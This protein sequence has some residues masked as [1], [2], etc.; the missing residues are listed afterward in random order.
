MRKQRGFTLIELMIVV[1]IIGILAAI[2]IPAFLEYMASGKKSEAEIALNRMGK[3]AKAE[4][5]RTGGYA[6]VDNPFYPAAFPAAGALHAKGT[7]AAPV[8]AGSGFDVYQ[9][10][11][12]DA[13]RCSYD[14]D[15]TSATQ[16]DAHGVGDFDNDAGAAPAAGGARM[17]TVTLLLRQNAADGTPN[18]EITVAGND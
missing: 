17:T 14:Y 16:V 2:A 10:V 12:E 5:T 11:V 15:A 8:V 7:W 3:K 1:A 9:F 18:T 6:T 13:W 4:F